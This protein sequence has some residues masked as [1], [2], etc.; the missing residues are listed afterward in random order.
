MFKKISLQ[1][2]IL[3]CAL[4]MSACFSSSDDDVTD[5][6]GK[7]AAALLKGQVAYTFRNEV[8]LVDAN[9]KNTRK[10]TSDGKRKTAI[11]FSANRQKIAY[12]TDKN[13][14]VIIDQNGKELARLS[15]FTNVKSFGWCNQDRTLYMLIGNKVELYGDTFTLPRLPMSNYIYDDMISVSI[16]SNNDVAYSY[17]TIN[18]STGNA[19]RSHMIK[20]KFADQTERAFEEQARV[21]FLKWSADSKH[22]YFQTYHFFSNVK[23][24]NWNMSKP[25]PELTDISNWYFPMV[26]TSDMAVAVSEKNGSDGH[27]LKIRSMYDSQYD[28]TLTT[29]S[30]STPI[31]FDWK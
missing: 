21:D 14:P 28:V 24:A 13:S 5:E 26:Y 7:Q 31:Y 22:L 10:L 20:I 27:D 9:G 3:F 23:M 8:Y 16:S 30:S 6:P 12:L 1:F 19:M 17:E 15:N 2:F 29:E 4:F 11:A 25:L 18:V